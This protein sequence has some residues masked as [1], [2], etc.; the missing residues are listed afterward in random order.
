MKPDK[1]QP[2]CVLCDPCH[3]RSWRQRQRRVV[4]RCCQKLSCVCL[5]CPKFAA[6]GEAVRSMLSCAKCIGGMAGIASLA[7]AGFFVALYIGKCA[8][9]VCCRD[10]DEAPPVHPRHNHTKLINWSPTH[11]EFIDVF[12]GVIGLAIVV[13]CCCRPSRS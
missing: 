11:I 1:P 6:G 4:H 8:L 10:V 12:F 7:V 3:E 9:W 2:K 5:W 13:C